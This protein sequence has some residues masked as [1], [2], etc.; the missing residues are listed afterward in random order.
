M[1]VPM[2]TRD[3]VLGAMTFVSGRSGRR[4]DTADLTL[5]EELARRCATAVDNARLFGE[6][7]Y[8]AKTLQ[9]S[10]LP[11]ELPDIP[12]LETAA[13]FQ[14]SGDGNDVGGDFYDLFETGRHGWTVVEIGRASC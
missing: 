9:E 13:R 5:A 10:L 3:R 6:R 7:T 12:G 4:F 8:I 1:I 11:A 2:V 14:A